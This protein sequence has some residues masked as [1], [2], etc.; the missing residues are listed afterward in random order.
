MMNLN[1]TVINVIFDAGRGSLSVQSREA[2]SGKPF[3][4]LPTPTRAGYA[5]DGWYLDGALVTADT[6]VAAEDDIRLV[7]RWKKVREINA[8]R[9]SYKKQKIAIAILSIVTLLLVGVVFLT[10]YSVSIYRVED[11]W[12]VDG[13]KYSETYYVKK[14]NGVYGLYDK[15][16]N[17]MEINPI[18]TYNMSDGSD[19]PY[20][21]YIAKKSGNQYLV[22]TATGDYRPYAVVDYGGDEVLGFRDRIL[23][24]PQITSSRVFSIEVKNQFGTYKFY[25]DKNGAV[26]LQGYEESPAMYDYTQFVSL[27]DACGYTITLDRLVM[28]GEESAVARLPDGSVDY[29][30]Y[31]LADVYE[32]GELVY[33]P[34]VFTIVKADYNATTGVYSE[35]QTSYTVK[36]GNALLSRTGY[37]M[38]LEGRD[39]IY[40]GDTVVEE[41]VL[42]PIEAMMVPTVVHATNTSTYLMIQNF[43]LGRIPGSIQSF[44]PEKP[45]TSGKPMVAFSYQELDDRLSTMYTVSPYVSHLDIMS[46]YT[47]HDN[48]V[49]DMLTL[50]YQIESKGCIKLGL[51]NADLEKYGLDKDVF[52]LVYDSPA[53]DSEGNQLGYY[54]NALLISQKTKDNTYYVASFVSDM[55]LEVDAAYFE[56]LEWDERDWYHE[57]FF[58]HNVGYVPSLDIE[59]DGKQFN[60]TASNVLS[61]AYY[62][63]A[64]GKIVRLDLSK[65]SVRQDSQGR[66]IYNDNGVDRT[67]RVFDFSKGDIYIKV[68]P[69]GQDPIY[70]PYYKYLIT[71]DRNGDWELAVVVKESGNDITY[72]YDLGTNSGENYSY[73]LV[74]VDGNGEEFDVAGAYNNSQGSRISALYQMTYWEEVKK[75]EPNGMTTYEWKRKET[76]SLATTIILRS[77]TED[78]ANRKLYQIPMVTSNLQASCAQ[79][80]LDYNKVYQ[81]K[82]DKG[83]IVTATISGTDNFRALFGKLLYYSLEGTIDTAEFEKTWGMTVKEFIEQKPYHAQF[84][85]TIKD[86]AANMNVMSA[87]SATVTDKKPTVAD[88]AEIKLWQQD[89]EHHVVVRLYQYSPTRSILTI[90][91]NGAEESAVFYVQSSYCDDILDAAEKVLAQIPVKPQGEI[92]G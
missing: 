35:S 86:A 7:A 37:Y 81:Y 14:Q 12:T 49:T 91:V 42:Q 23:M 20:V 15:D 79:G 5:F 29:A 41:T 38:Q 64:Q 25:R 59:I 3:G 69:K 48:N 78:D 75:T 83:E 84:S 11:E 27:C 31:G 17:L 62:E 44:D 73:Q 63:D 47:L 87:T 13:V 16:G 50:L 46:G 30:A 80:S 6:V 66:W 1:E 68:T 34:T 39:T 36:V 10:K 53:T 76:P 18:S 82:N 74:Y 72:R 28:S 26:K 22:D 65:G 71:K 56:F 24:Y 4:K 70:Y 51:N 54:S 85:Y 92:V 90:S 61:Y 8:P 21:V 89:N 32:N 45:E 57:Y 19:I 77:T 33:S 2:V 52:Y 67:L 58:Q 88:N 9:S 55:I 40:I 43:Q 60:F